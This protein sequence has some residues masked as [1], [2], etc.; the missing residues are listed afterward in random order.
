MK[1][2]EIVIE[3]GRTEGQYWRDLWRYREL[4][5]FLAWRDLL[6]RYKQ[7]A[8]GVAWAVGRPLLTMVVFTFAFGKVANLSAPQGVP[9]ALWV[10]AALLPWQFFANS[11]T[12]S[13]ASLVVNSHLITRVYFPRMIVPASSLAPSLVDLVISSSILVALFG[14]YAVVPDWR[15]VFLPLFT[16]LAF[17]AALGLGL[18]MAALTVR[19]RDFR[20]ITGFVVQFGVYV[21]PVGFDTRVVVEKL[22]AAWAP[23]YYLNPMV[24]VLD[25][26]RWA[27]FGER[28]PMNWPGFLISSEVAVILLALGIRRFRRTERSFADTI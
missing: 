25:G 23:L 4:F 21:S 17:V 22:P 9:Y 6:V 14:W 11:L 7:T 24:G 15:I 10:F 3:A 13:S 28:V 5:W 2:D 16:L 1:T 18:W 26:F 19:Y 20:F 8:F 27:L 12:D